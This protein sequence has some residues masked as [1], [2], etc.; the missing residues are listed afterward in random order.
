MGGDTAHRDLLLLLLLL[1]QL[2]VT[3]TM[4]MPMTQQLKKRNLTMKKKL[5]LFYSSHWH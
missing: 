1:H 2:W 3:M 5:Q 4:T